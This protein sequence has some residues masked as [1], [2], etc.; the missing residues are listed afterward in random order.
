MFEAVLEISADH[1]HQPLNP[2]LATTG[3]KNAINLPILKLP[4]L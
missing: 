1:R 4:I 3:Q 2:G